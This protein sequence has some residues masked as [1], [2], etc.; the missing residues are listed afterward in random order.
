MK[1]EAE[2][3]SGTLSFS[4]YKKT[5]TI[6]YDNI[7]SHHF[8]VPIEVYLDEK[9]KEKLDKARTLHEV[10]RILHDYRKHHKNNKNKNA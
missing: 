1:R 4:S 3:V 9:Y 8:N 5:E 2:I 6:T 10:E 7:Y